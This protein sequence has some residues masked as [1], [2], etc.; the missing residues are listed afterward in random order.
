MIVCCVWWMLFVSLYMLGW[1][2]S[3]AW[4][5]WWWWWWCWWHN[6]NDD[7][8]DDDD[9]DRGSLD[10]HTHAKGLLSQREREIIPLSQ[11]GCGVK[12]GLC[13]ESSHFPTRG[14]SVLW[15]LFLFDFV[16][17]DFCVFLRMISGKITTSLSHEVC[18]SHVC[19]KA[20]TKQKFAEKTSMGSCFVTVYEA[21]AWRSAWGRV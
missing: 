11:R 12:P 4:W 16:Q 20:W 2:K 1:M 18:S 6:F 14:P 5:W 13:G 15:T 21:K 17:V 3:R 8:D 10:G 9:D 7:D 19:W